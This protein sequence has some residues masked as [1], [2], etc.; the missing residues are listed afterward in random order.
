MLLQNKQIMAAQTAVVIGAS[1]LVG[2]HVVKHLLADDAFG[3]VRVLVRRPLGLQHPKLEQQ[4]VDFSNYNDYQTKL[5]SGDCIFCC[6]G[7]T[8]A[9]VKG[10][11]TEYRKIDFDI[12]VNSARFGSEAGFQQYLLVSAMGANAQ[13]RIFYSRLKGE[14]E[15][16]IS[17]FRFTSFHVFRP[18]FLLGNRKEQRIGESIGKSIA[19]LFAFLIPSKY[20]PIEAETVAK[21]MITAAKQQTNGLAVHYYADMTGN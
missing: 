18:S 2:S 9:N 13:S 15:D 5:G 21:A 4:I 1:G 12:P 11:K 16:I 14:V 20:K 19:K 10:D 6:I 8:N 3:K 7:T 17:T